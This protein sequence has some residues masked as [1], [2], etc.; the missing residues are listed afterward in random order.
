LQILELQNPQTGETVS[1]DARSGERLGGPELVLQGGLD[2]EVEPSLRVGPYAS[3]TLAVYT[4]DG[5]KCSRAEL[6]CA[7]GSS[8]DGSGVHSWLSVGLRGSYA[9]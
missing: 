2:F 5:I 3:A 6:S 7:G 1:V 8:I 9:P 4:R